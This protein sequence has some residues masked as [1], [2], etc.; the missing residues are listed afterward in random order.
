MKAIIATNSNCQEEFRWAESNSWNTAR[1]RGEMPLPKRSLISTSC[2][3]STP[4]QTQGTSSVSFSRGCI[5]CSVADSEGR[6]AFT[7]SPA[8]F[9]LASCV[10][11]GSIP[12]RPSPSQACKIQWDHSKKEVTMQEPTWL[13]KNT[14]WTRL[15]S[16]QVRIRSNHG[17]TTNSTNSKADQRAQP[18]L[19][20]PLRRW[21]EPLLLQPWMKS[22][23]RRNQ[24]HCPSC[25]QGW[26]HEDTPHKGDQV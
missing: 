1:V 5:F 20:M 23:S 18:D 8:P 17:Q 19:S 13:K 16:S 11:P 15:F 9:P 7:E 26:L 14:L 4:S 22:G 25:P 12:S 6:A 10:S 21:A 2:Q 24:R 3:A